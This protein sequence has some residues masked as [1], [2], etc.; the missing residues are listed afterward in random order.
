MANRKE[1]T[2]ELMEG[3]QA[4]RRTVAFK[5]PESAN[6]PRITPAQWGALMMIEHDGESTVKDVAKALAITS[7]AATQLVDG[8]VE[9][10]YVKREEHAEDRRRMTLM[11]SQKTKKQIEKMKKQAT[12]QF[13][14]FFEV[15]DDREFDQLILLHKKIFERHL[16]NRNL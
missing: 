3:F 11:L 15:L 1:K 16:K 6:M 13:L 8:L 9:S 5:M 2:K 10:G 14:K 7:S 12:R 4:L